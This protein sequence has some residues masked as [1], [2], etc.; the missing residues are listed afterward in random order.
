MFPGSSALENQLNTKR[1]RLEKKEQNGSSSKFPVPYETNDG[2]AE[3]D[4]KLIPINYNLAKH[5]KDFVFPSNS[6]LPNKSS[7]SRQNNTKAP[8]KKLVI[9]PL[10]GNLTIK[11]FYL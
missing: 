5:G 9:K 2:S 6:D 1:I 11:R 7:H 10:K 4:E 8:V 3:T